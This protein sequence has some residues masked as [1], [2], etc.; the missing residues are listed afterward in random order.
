MHVMCLIT[1]VSGT[2]PNS[3]HGKM[4][5]FL[6]T[7]PYRLQRDADVKNVVTSTVD[8]RQNIP[9]TSRDLLQ[10]RVRL[11]HIVASVVL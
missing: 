6:V 5:E 1:A 3:R 9:L 10:E 7:L 11:C 4:A 2:E 8:S